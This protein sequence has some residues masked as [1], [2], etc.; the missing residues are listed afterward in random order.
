M[1]IQPF[2]SITFTKKEQDALKASNRTTFEIH[3]MDLAIMNGIRRV[4]L[5]KIP[6]LGFM[7][8]KEVS[9][10]IQKNNGPLHNEFMIHRIGMIPIHFTEEEIEGFVDNE[11]EFSIDVKNTISSILN[12]TTHDFKGTRNGVELAQKDIY[13]L[14][15]V[16]SVT[17]KPV[18]ITRLRQGEELAFTAT[19]VKQ[20]ASD[21]SAFSP[22]SLCTFFYVQ[23]A[24]KNKDVKD[25][26]QRE[27][28]Y[29][30]NE[31]NE[32]TILQFSIEP[33]TSLS[34]TYLVAK[35]LE[36]LRGICET[37]DKEMDVVGSTKVELRAHEEI[38]DTY[39]LHVYDENDTF[40]NLFQSLI[41]NEFIRHPKKILDNKFDM[42][43]I[44]YYAPHPLD[45]KIV[46]R[47]TL[48]NEDV[49]PEEHEFKDAYK[50]CL[51]MIDQQL[52]EVYDAWIRF[53]G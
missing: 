15:P 32:A 1:S 14:F 9:I 49:H 6:T 43:Y 27:R 28:N 3:N 38:K 52:K 31:Y 26:L 42:T 16:N 48:K 46:I 35:A 29:L 8:E 7:G 47:M 53:E 10:Q 44:G 36:I 25:I 45:P 5:S 12:V 21:H 17:K 51:R 18:L 22:V 39:D 34:P 23:D 2:K 4:I 41:Y 37:V 20:T 30:K 40:G 50:S 13:R 19:V 33:E 11:W 24:T